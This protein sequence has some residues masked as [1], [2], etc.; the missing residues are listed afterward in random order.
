MRRTVLALTI[1][2]MI[3]MVVCQEQASQ[4]PTAESLSQGLTGSECAIGR[5]MASKLLTEV[6]KLAEKNQL[7]FNQGV[8]LFKEWKLKSGLSTKKA[9]CLTEEFLD[10]FTETT[11]EGFRAARITSFAQ[12]SSAASSTSK[13]S[14]DSIRRM[15]EVKMMVLERKFNTR[16]Q[17]ISSEVSRMEQEIEGANQDIRQMKGKCQCVRTGQIFSRL[18]ALRRRRVHYIREKSVIQIKKIEA[19]VSATRSFLITLKK[20]LKSTKD[21]E[22]LREIRFFVKST[23]SKLKRLKKKQAKQEKKF[24]KA[25]KA[26]KTALKKEID[27]LIFRSKGSLS[28]VERMRIQIRIQSL[29]KSL[30]MEWKQQVKMKGMIIKGKI[31]DLKAKLSDPH[32][33]PAER[34]RILLMIK[35][36]KAKKEQ[37]KRHLMKWVLKEKIKAKGAKLQRITN[38]INKLKEQ[39]QFVPE[40]PQKVALLKRIAKLEKKQRKILSKKEKFVIKALHLEIKRLKYLKEH[41]KTPEQKK[42][43]MK[44]LRA[45]KKKLKAAKK[46]M[47]SAKG[48]KSSKLD[49]KMAKKQRQL[50]MIRDEMATIKDPKILKKLKLKELVLI[51]KI[52]RIKLK[53][54][55]LKVQRLKEK[56]RR[57]KESLADITDPVQRARILKK[58]NKLRNKVNR[59]KRRMKSILKKLRKA[60]ITKDFLMRKK[61]DGIKERIRKLKEKISRTT[62]PEKLRHLKR[63]L[64]KAH[65]KL[66]LTTKKLQRARIAHES[67]QIMHLQALLK[68]IK[69]PEVLKRIQ[70]K[71]NSF[72]TR[73]AASILQ[74]KKADSKLR[75]IRKARLA[76]LKHKSDLLM[77]KITSYFSAPATDAQRKEQHHFVKKFIHLQ[78]ISYKTE[79]KLKHSTYMN[80]LLI[81]RKLTPEEKKKIEAI[82]ASILKSIVEGFVSPRV[83]PCKERISHLESLII[84]N[85]KLLEKIKEK[86]FRED[87]DWA[88]KG[89]Q[90]KLSVAKEICGLDVLK[91]LPS[92]EGCPCCG[93]TIKMFQGRIEFLNEQILHMHKEK[94]E[95]VQNAKLLLSLV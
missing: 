53:K 69:D 84:A 49:H 27:T 54:Q 68:K 41:A 58:L 4:L 29:K 90:K 72:I 5:Q 83:L 86:K 70:N 22:K 57:L 89:N 18:S 25:L 11:F 62:D 20:L 30:V 60:R 75:K 95:R 42:E 46:L 6:R 80:L 17:E 13:D 76:R 43:I 12:S 82:K 52:N 33:P 59:V 85:M 21:P 44:K 81:K 26:R 74:Y 40:G 45:L 66:A 7:N 73:R 37:E 71:L 88:I 15:R 91:D 92:S 32:L 8:E 87:L 38:R 47:R 93:E 31:R 67:R 28:P 48:G 19:Q 77:T 78:V 16:T 2:A 55:K 24:L 3:S 39:L 63:K 50:Q 64:A 61:V 10:R 1:C 56:M 35:R 36:L 34:K 23:T 94:E 9:E 14:I 65:L 79:L 51:R